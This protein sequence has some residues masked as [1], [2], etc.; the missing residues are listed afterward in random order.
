MQTLIVNQTMTFRFTFLV[1]ALPV[2][3]L[4][5][6]S[7][8]HEIGAGFGAFNYTGDLVRT[9]NPAFSKPAFTV[10]YRSNISPIVSFK[11][12]LGFGTLAANDQRNP[13]DTAAVKRNTSF[14]LSMMEL[15]GT[16]EYHFLDWH[17]RRQRLK[18]TPYLYAGG[19]IFVFSGNDKK[20]VDYSNVQI[21]IPFGGGVKYIINPNWY[22]TAEFGIR[23]TFFDYLDNISGGKLNDKNYRFGNVY[24]LDNY[25]FTGI[26][27]TRT[28]YDI[29]CAQSPY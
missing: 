3:C 23:K 18:F 15:N 29:P 8:E 28:F 6:V 7:R 17:D 1:L 11:T 4:G 22:L 10:F 21:T 13:I 2:L 9:Y 27:L 14:N 12:S 20:P 5:Q 25:F 19:G 26:T 16:F 24:D